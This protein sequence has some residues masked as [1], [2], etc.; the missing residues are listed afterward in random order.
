MHSLVFCEHF[1]NTLLYVFFILF[2]YLPLSKCLKVSLTPSTFP[3][4]G[5]SGLFFF[6]VLVLL[7]VTQNPF[8][9]F[10]LTLIPKDECGSIWPPISLC[11]LL[12][13][14]NIVLHYAFEGHAS[15]HSITNVGRL[16]LFI[17]DFYKLIVGWTI[18]TL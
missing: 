9:C 10:F 16:P 13:L 4:S 11:S 7:S 2:V 3:S 8:D 6:C 1:S 18:L 12:R 14:R 17:H 5:K 15:K